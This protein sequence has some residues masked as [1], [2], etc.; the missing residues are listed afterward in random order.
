MPAT[1]TRRPASSGIDARLRQLAELMAVDEPYDR[2]ELQDLL[3][4]K[5]LHR[6]NFL[7]VVGVAKRRRKADALRREATAPVFRDSEAET[8]LARDRES[9]RQ[10]CVADCEAI[11][12]E[13]DE[14][15][16]AKA[17]AMAPLVELDARLRGIRM[18]R[19]EADRQRQ[20]VAEEA[21]ATLLETVDPAIESKIADRRQQLSDLQRSLQAAMSQASGVNRPQ[22]QNQ[23]DAL[24][25]ADAKPVG[26]R[27]IHADNHGAV[28]DAVASKIWRH[29]QANADVASLQRQ[30]ADVEAEIAQLEASRLDWRNFAL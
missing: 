28:A 8:E 27:H 14:L 13:I 18:Q 26:S 24:I 23:L 7:A 2:D 21:T 22:L 16:T 17:K 10:S 9:L 4:E 29:D 5:F 20:R 25:F 15:E 30:I 12:R 19:F 1:L 6:P 11:Q 3:D